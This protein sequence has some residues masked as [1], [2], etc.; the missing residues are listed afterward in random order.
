MRQITAFALVMLLVAA[1]VAGFAAISQTRSS[2]SST[3]GFSGSH[4]GIILSHPTQPLAVF[5]GSPSPTNNSADCPIYPMTTLM[6]G[7]VSAI[8]GKSLLLNRTESG[9][10]L[11]PPFDDRGLPTSHFDSGNVSLSLYY[12]ARE[13][14]S[15]IIAASVTNTGHQVVTIN[16]FLIFGSAA[17]RSGYGPATDLIAQAVDLAPHPNWQGRCTGNEPPVSTAQ[18]LLPGQSL[19]V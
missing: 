12:I 10:A 3:T 9:S 4:G 19:T 7:V 6:S 17:A 16:G 5:L 13:T 14:Q 15:P 11:G 1:S 8:P 2:L 18:I